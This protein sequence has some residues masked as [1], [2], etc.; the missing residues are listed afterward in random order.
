MLSHIS[1][2]LFFQSPLP[3][4]RAFNPDRWITLLLPNFL[5]LPKPA[6]VAP[7]QDGILPLQNWALLFQNFTS[8]CHWK[9]NFGSGIGSSMC[10]LR[11]WILTTTQDHVNAS[12]LFCHF[13]FSSFLLITW[14]LLAFLL[15][16]KIKI[17]ITSELL[18]KLP[19]TKKHP[20][21]LKILPY[22]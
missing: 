15:T 6:L 11:V 17:D 1:Q 10:N 4:W 7:C 22:C 16:C 12:H 2:I 5:T 3:P 21:S 13:L 9:S 8:Y 20:K 18:E 14:S 19:P